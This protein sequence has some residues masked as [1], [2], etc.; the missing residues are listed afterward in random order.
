[1]LPIITNFQTLTGVAPFLIGAEVG[2]VASNTVVLTYSKSCDPSSVP[3]T[4]D[5]AVSGTVQTISTVTFY[6]NQVRLTM[7]GDLLS[8]D[9]LAVS[10][11]PGTNK[12]KDTSNN[13][14]VA[15]SSEPVTNNT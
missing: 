15:L 1:M 13:L 14:A 4:G 5:F 8:T 3:A 2:L 11:T 10:Y 6:Y 9:T 12:L 7:S